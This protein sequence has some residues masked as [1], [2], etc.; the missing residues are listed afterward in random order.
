M[1][2]GSARSQE[3]PF[4]FTKARQCY[5]AALWVDSPIPWS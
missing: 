5:F 4:A 2:A 1:L 3:L